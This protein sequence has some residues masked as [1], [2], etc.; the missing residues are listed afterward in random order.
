MEPIDITMTATVRPDIIRKTL[1]SYCK[2]I[3]YEKDRYRLIINI[4]PV[5][6]KVNPETI[7]NICKEFI[8]N[9]IYNVP[10]KPSFPSAVIWVW[11]QTRT[12]FVFHLEDD[13]LLERHVDIDRL[14]TL[15][16]KY[17][18]MACLRFCKYNIPSR[19][20][21]TL[22]NAKYEYNPDGF[23]ITENHNQFGLN[24]VLIKREFIQESLPLM[25]HN[26][27]PEKQFRFT[28]KADT[29]MN[30]LINKWRY[31]IYG[32]PGSKV[33]AIDNGVNWKLY[34]KFKKPDGQQFLVWE[35]KN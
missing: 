1:K 2:N 28:K 3:F 24:P 19:E 20:R 33:L 13:W 30:R 8:P 29:P 23:F 17:P 22:F 4:D 21:I 14:I 26:R 16:N 15:L 11:S 27:N 31:A 25:V 12:N 32:G 35:P 5:G 10:D 34:N 9:V 6:E 18:Q 7:V